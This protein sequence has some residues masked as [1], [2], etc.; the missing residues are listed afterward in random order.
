MSTGVIILAMQ[1]LFANAQ[2][3]ATANSSRLLENVFGT[4]AGRARQR[5]CELAA[6]ETLA[7]VDILFDIRSQIAPRVTTLRISVSRSRAINIEPVTATGQTIAI[8][9]CDL[10]ATRWI[11]IASFS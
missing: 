1:I 9:K 11:R 5:L 2:L 3:E 7:V 8:A 10:G 6:A 4:A